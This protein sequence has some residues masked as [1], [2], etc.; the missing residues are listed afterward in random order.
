[1]SNK[2][3][4]K[5]EDMFEYDF[6]SLVEFYFRPTH[7]PRKMAAAYSAIL[8][9]RDSVLNGPLSNVDVA[10]TVY[11]FAVGTAKNMHV[12]VVDIQNLANQVV[13]TLEKKEYSNMK[14]R[15]ESNTVVYD[16]LETLKGEDCEFLLEHMVEEEKTHPG[17]MLAT[18]KRNIGVLSEVKQFVRGSAV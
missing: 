13:E 1:M 17:Q 2:T 7:D 18:L 12:S 3:D 6:D 8:V 4:F 9:L 15:F 10:F 14:L 5:F 11:F 16:A